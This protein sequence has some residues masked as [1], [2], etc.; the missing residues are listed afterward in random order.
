LAQALDDP[1]AAA[2]AEKFFGLLEREQGNI[3]AGKVHLARAKSMYEA[4]G[5]VYGTAICANDLGIIHAMQSNLET[6]KTCFEESL[7]L[8]RQVGDKMGV[9]YAIGNLGVIA[10][11]QGNLALERVLQEESLHLKRE[12]GDKQGIGNGLKSLGL[13]ALEQQQIELALDYFAQSLQIF[14]ELGRRYTQTALLFDFATTAW[15]LGDS[16]AALEFAAA[17]IHWR[18]AIRSLPPAMW[19]NAQKDWQAQ[20]SFSPA[21]LAKLEFDVQKL[22]LE[23]VI[24]TALMWKTNRIPQASTQGEHLLV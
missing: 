19:L 16:Q 20:S 4:L 11:Q 22:S 9:A 10:G 23:Q 3:E 17:A 14:S 1:Q 18:Y 12:L 24:N 15:T 8:K 6:A 13:N 21:E 2:G 5:D 7:H